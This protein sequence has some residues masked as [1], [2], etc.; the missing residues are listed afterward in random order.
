M[1]YPLHLT[2]GRWERILH[3]I[4]LLSAPISREHAIMGA[5]CSSSSCS[6]TAPKT[7][8]TASCSRSYLS[9]ARRIT[10]TGKS[11]P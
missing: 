7:T 6:G 5:I 2:L 9:N 3:A 4:G 10:G 8:A 1:L 11:L